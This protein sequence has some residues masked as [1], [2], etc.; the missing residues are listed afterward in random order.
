MSSWCAEE[1]QP[2]VPG[3]ATKARLVDI[4]EG[5]QDECLKDRSAAPRACWT[6]CRCRRLS[7]PDLLPRPGRA[8]PVRLVDEPVRR[9][10]E[11]VEVRGCRRTR[12]V[13]AAREQPAG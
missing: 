7:A 2:A 5:V 1:V 3:R 10:G 8:R 4:A 13:R 12:E 6:G 11:R 9:K